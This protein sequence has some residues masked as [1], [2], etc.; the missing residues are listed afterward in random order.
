MERILRETV[1]V[2]DKWHDFTLYGP[3]GSLLACRQPN[4]VDLWWHHKPPAAPVRW[5]LIVVGT[6]HQVP[7]RPGVEWLGTAVTA[8]GDL[9]WHLLGVRNPKD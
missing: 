2:D 3:I 8:G 7:Q 4:R 6:G 1:P 9:V 5:S